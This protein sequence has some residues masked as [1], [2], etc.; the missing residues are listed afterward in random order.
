MADARADKEWNQSAEAADARKRMAEAF[1]GLGMTETQSQ[2]AAEGRPISGVDADDPIFN[3]FMILDNYHPRLAHLLM[4][5]AQRHNLTHQREFEE[6]PRPSEPQTIESDDGTEIPLFTEMTLH[7][8]YWACAW[9]LCTLWCWKFLPEG[10]QMMNANP[11][12]W[13]H[14]PFET[15][16]TN[17][18]PF[19]LR[20]GWDVLTE[21]EEVF[22]ERAEKALVSYIQYQRNLA[23][24]RGLTETKEKRQPLHFDWLALYQVKR[25]SWEQIADWDSQQPGANA[26]EAGAIMKGAHDA[27]ALC[28]LNALP[29]KL[30]RP[31][32][33]K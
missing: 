19:R 20:P 16:L 10:S 21:T 2:R 23:E 24:A 31:K 25:L 4:H 3:M 6:E 28:K 30:G 27:A 18:P 17:E 33:R 5:W 7:K 8:D 26:K 13:V 1:M 22:R 12:E 14:N 32:K 29:G 9:A 11:P 15:R